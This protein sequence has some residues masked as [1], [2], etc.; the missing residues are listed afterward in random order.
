MLAQHGSTQAVALPRLQTQTYVDTPSGTS[1]RHLYVGQRLF[2]LESVAS[3]AHMFKCKKCEDLEGLAVLVIG[4][5]RCTVSAASELRHTTSGKMQL[6]FCQ[7]AQSD[8]HTWDGAC[9]HLCNPLQDSCIH[10]LTLKLIKVP[11]IFIVILLK[12]AVKRRQLSV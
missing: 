2:L 9:L 10:L 11:S 6:C 3:A 1:Q 12:V 8:C 5:W 7:R 4:F